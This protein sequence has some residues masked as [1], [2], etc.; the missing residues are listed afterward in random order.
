M[1]ECAD[2]FWWATFRHPFIIYDSVVRL[3]LGTRHGVYVHCP[4]SDGRRAL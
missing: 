1:T 4:A 3:R 2:I